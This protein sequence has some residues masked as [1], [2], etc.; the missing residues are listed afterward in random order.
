ML[1]AVAGAPREKTLHATHVATALHR[2]ASVKGGRAA[3]ATPE[4]DFLLLQLTRLARDASL[5]AGSLSIIFWS[6]ARLLPPSSH[7]SD[8]ARAAI[9]DLLPRAVELSGKL[10][11]Q[12][13]SNVA[14]AGSR[15]GV[16][17][18]AFWLAIASGIERKASA[19]AMSGIELSMAANAMA[20]VYPT[21]PP[22][23]LSAT[24][25]VK[26]VH[27]CVQTAVAEL[28]SFPGGVALA[29]LLFA[30]ASVPIDALR[31]DDVATRRVLAHIGEHIDEFEPHHV[32]SVLWSF[33]HLGGMD[34]ETMETLCSRITDTL[35]RAADGALATVALSLPW[36]PDAPHEF[37]LSLAAEVEKRLPEL[38]PDW[39]AIHFSALAYTRV[40]EANAAL[41][42]KVARA[43]WD[44]P[45]SSRVHMLATVGR[46]RFGM[47]L[48]NRIG[49]PDEATCA[50][51]DVLLLDLLTAIEPEECSARQL[52]DFLLSLVR[53]GNRDE[54]AIAIR[55][56]QPRVIV[57]LRHLAAEMDDDTFCHIFSNV[58]ALG[59]SSESM[60]VLLDRA[61]AIHWPLLKDV[62]LTHML[63][64]LETLH[65]QDELAA[66]PLVVA[67]AEEVVRRVDGPGMASDHRMMFLIGLSVHKTS[68]V[69]ASATQRAINAL[70]DSLC[71]DVPS[72]SINQL[73]TVL[74]T[75]SQS[76]LPVS[77]RMAAAI[78][79]R[80]E[81][82]LP[83][84][85]LPVL[86]RILWQC[87]RLEPQPDLAALLAQT[88][89]L[90][91]QE[92]SSIES[93]AV[94]TLVAVADSVDAPVPTLRKRMAAV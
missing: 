76:S 88:D 29:N 18:D 41:L 82:E 49:A 71:P 83:S 26:A 22:H 36:L 67:I 79:E 69:D 33:R 44:Q 19:G 66:A 47:V 15:L 53:M 31:D 38:H 48:G 3:L 54:F 28:D 1:Q 59:W 75:V 81:R 37:L 70:L 78:L 87:L 4:G 17:D 65:H 5:H 6:V 25:I 8:E 16:Q 43:M 62:A 9:A 7:A 35:Y 77:R 45:N 60:D 85:P 23:L 93:A 39:L 90:V 74:R 27:A 52:S 58:H 51:L 94:A 46:Y 21:L 10:T 91:A 24:V 92:H 2:L 42:D 20:R 12:G 30:A 61:R 40:L 72:I 11:S 63:R 55:D 89:A 14:W 50:R 80:V 57:A 32:T 34:E 56:L 68:L 73:P 84:I 13:V 64:G 86:A